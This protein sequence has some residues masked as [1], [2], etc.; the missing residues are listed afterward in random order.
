VTE[1]WMQPGAMAR[2]YPG[3]SDYPSTVVLIARVGDDRWRVAYGRDG[4]PTEPDGPDWVVEAEELLR[5]V[6]DARDGR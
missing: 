4:R 6:P 1:E 2:W 5:Y 3:Q